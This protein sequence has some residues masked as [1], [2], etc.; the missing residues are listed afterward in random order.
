MHVR[1]ARQIAAKTEMA[2]K[3]LVHHFG[4]TSG[5]LLYK[6]A[7][8]TNFVFEAKTAKGRFMLRIAGSAAKYTDFIKEQWATEKARSQGIPAPEIVE[9]G[10]DIV[11][12][13]YMLQKKIDGLEATEHPDRLP[14][15]QQLGQY[16]Q[17]IH[18]IPTSG[19]GQVFDWSTDGRRK[20]KNWI[21]YLEKEW[22]ATARLG[23][24]QQQHLLPAR[25]IA[26]LQSLLKKI[27]QWDYPSVLH[28]GDLRLKN[29]IVNKA[30]DILGILDWENCTSQVA[31]YWDLSLAL[32]D[33]SIEGKHSFIK[34]YGLDIAD[35]DHHAYAL[36]V[37]NLLNYVPELR[38]L[39]KKKKHQELELYRLRLNGALDLFS[40]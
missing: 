36:T 18:R 35:F 10:R 3:I 24:L 1:S 19:F 38:D 16:A 32:H 12:L 5:Q 37:F 14:I 25:K 20:E 17:R 9:I 15:L 2:R 7:G 26:E 23:F 8:K 22:Q 4:K 28:H 13:P 34:G 21:D 29:V 27:K 11:A 6:P 30:G 33:L 40:L 31:P 39:F